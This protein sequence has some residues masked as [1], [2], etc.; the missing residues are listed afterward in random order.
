MESTIL[1]LPV[2]YLFTNHFIGQVLPFINE[3]R[4]TLLHWHTKY[5]SILLLF[6]VYIGIIYICILSLFSMYF[7]QIQK[8]NPSE[9]M[10]V[11]QCRANGLNI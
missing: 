8:Q 7:Q 5:I 9:I 4:L 3:L 10:N 11:S 6:Y 1:I 2:K